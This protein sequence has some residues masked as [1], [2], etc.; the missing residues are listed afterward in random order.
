MEIGYIG[1]GKDISAGSFTKIPMDQEL[2]SIYYFEPAVQPLKADQEFSLM[3]GVLVIGSMEDIKNS[4]GF[5]EFHPQDTSFLATRITTGLAGVTSILVGERLLSNKIAL[6]EG[7]GII[8]TPSYEALRDQ[9]VIT[10]KA[11]LSSLADVDIPLV[12][13]AA[14]LANLTALYGQPITGINGIPPDATGNFTLLPL[15]CTELDPVEGGLRIEN[16]CSLPCCDKSVLDDAYTSISELNLRYARMEGYYQ[17]IG[18]NIND[19][20][21]RMIALEL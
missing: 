14:I 2:N 15:D 17:S 7:A 10:F 11:D 16:P 9:T 12:S 18:R 8:I 21:S 19:L 3:S 4:P 13:D 1:N 6:K 5:W 20:Q